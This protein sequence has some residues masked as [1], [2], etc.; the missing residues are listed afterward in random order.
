MLDEETDA[1]LRKRAEI[2]AGFRWVEPVQPLCQTQ[3]KKPKFACY[4]IRL[5][6]GGCAG[7]IDGQA[8][9]FELSREF[10][11]MPR[12]LKKKLNRSGELVGIR[13]RRGRKM[14]RKD[15]RFR[16]WWRKF[17]VTIHGKT[18]ADMIMNPGPV[19]PVLG[20]IF[21][22]NVRKMMRDLSNRITTATEAE[23]ETAGV[24]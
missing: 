15:A 1:V 14:E 6:G 7:L 17:M 12:R 16:K 5:E 2:D 11:N 23:E 9:A 20:K 24:E 22:G 21:V 19:D 3:Q 18:I 13:S 8:G 10:N 4:A